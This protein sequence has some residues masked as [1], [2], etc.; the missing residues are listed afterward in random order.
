MKENIEVALREEITTLREKEK[1]LNAYPLSVDLLT[2]NDIGKLAK[3]FMQ[4]DRKWKNSV[5]QEV[6]VQEQTA[7]IKRYG[8]SEVIELPAYL[9]KV[10]KQPDEQFFK[11]GTHCKAIYS[12]D[13]QFYPCIIEK[14][15][16]EG[17]LVKYKKYNTQ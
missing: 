10:L 2:A 9:L 4:E 11:E 16:Q 3:C 14:I 8:S 5:V 7:K 1:K 17:Y 6:D 15:L 12:G 13:G